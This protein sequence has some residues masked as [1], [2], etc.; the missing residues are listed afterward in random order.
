MTDKLSPAMT[1]CGSAVAA[2]LSVWGHI[3]LWL[4]ENHKIFSSLGILTGIVCAIIG[5][6]IQ[7]RTYRA[8]RKKGEL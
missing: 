3:G 7:V 5:A 4:A 6:T 8:K 1:Y 2:G